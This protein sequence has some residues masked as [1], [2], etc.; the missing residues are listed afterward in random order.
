MRLLNIFLL[1]VCVTGCRQTPQRTVA[2]TH[3]PELQRL[4]AA[5]DAAKTQTDMNFA[6]KKISEFWDARL[7]SVESRIAQRLDAEQQKAFAASK[8]RWRSYRTWE[9]QFRSE[10]FASGS[11]QPLIANESYSGL[12]KHRV[13]ELESLWIS[14]LEAAR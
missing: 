1:L 6:S 3:D 14:T 10:F 4:T 11:I 7:A 9:V 8:E 12:T 13:T 5:L 2:V